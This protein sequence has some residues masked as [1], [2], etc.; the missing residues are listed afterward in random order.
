VKPAPFEYHA[1][2]SV[3][4]AVSRLAGLGDRANVLLRE[5]CNLTMR[6]ALSGT[7]CR[8]TGCQGIFAA[9][10][11]AAARQAPGVGHVGAPA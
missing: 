3:A 5:D 2:A 11:P 4:D 1:P 9:M 8:C 7:P 6:V 10:R